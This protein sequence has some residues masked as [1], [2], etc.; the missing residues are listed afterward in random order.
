M[1][2][3]ETGYKCIEAGAH[4]VMIGD[5]LAYQ[6]GTYLSPEQMRRLSFPVLQEQVE[7]LKELDIPVFFHSDGNLNDVMD[8]LLAMEFDGLQGLEPGAGM[9]LAAVKEKSGGRI[10]LMGNIDL[11]CLHP[12]AEEKEI[13]DAVETTFRAAPKPGHYI[14]GTSG[15]LHKDLPVEKV[16]TMYSIAR[17][18]A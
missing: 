9:D 16:K 1:E 18:L 14:F 11:S 17:R 8:D 10:C 12:E 5:D 4:A 6:K 7:R 13:E 2:E 3:L 15:G